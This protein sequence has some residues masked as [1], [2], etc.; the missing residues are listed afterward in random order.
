MDGKSLLSLA[1]AQ[2]GVVVSP[3]APQAPLP[4]E[5]GVTPELELERSGDQ[6]YSLDEPEITV[7]EEDP[8]VTRLTSVSDAQLD[9]SDPGGCTGALPGP[10]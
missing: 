3:T 9:K 6:P 1:M 4:H 5:L 7:P 10:R 8:S 2:R